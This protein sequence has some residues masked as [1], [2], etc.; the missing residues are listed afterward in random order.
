MT[1]TKI[2]AVLVSAAMLSVMVAC[3]ADEASAPAAPAAA[4][5]AQAAQAITYQPAAPQAAVAAAPAAAAISAPALAVAPAVPKAKPTAVPTPVQKSSELSWMD[6][7]LQGPGYN[8]SWGQPIKGGIMRYGASHKFNG[9]DPNYGH[10]FEGPQFLPTYNALLRYDPWRGLGGQIEGDLA[11]TWEVQDGGKTVV[12]K[13]REGVNFQTNPNLPAEIVDQVS[14]DSFTCEDAKASLDFGVNPPT[15]ILHSGPRAALN[16]MSGSSCIDD[17]TFKVEFEEALARTIPQFAGALG[18]P[19]NMD[20]DFLDWFLNNYATTDPQENVLDQTTPETYMYGTGTGAFVPLEFEVDVQSK[21]RANPDYFREGLPLI[22]G[23]DQFIITDATAR[24]SALIT[25]Q[26]DYYG[27]GSASLLPAHVEQIQ[28][29][30][31]DKFTIQPTLHSW[32]KGI[33]VNLLREPFDNRDVRMAMHLALD[34]DDWV[35]FNMA[36]GISGVHRHTLWMPPGSIWALPDE[37]LGEMP[38]WR[39]GQGKIDDIAEA[40]RLLDAA[41]GAGNRFSVECMAQ[42]A[43]IYIDGCEYFQDQMKRNLGVDVTIS[44]VESAV[45]G[46]RGRGAQYDVHYGSKVRTNVADPDDFYMIHLI[47]ERESWYYRGTGREEAEP[48]LTAQLVELVEKQSRELDVAKRVEIVH[49]IERILATEAMFSIPYPWTYIF[50]A[51]STEIKGW[52]LY[53]HPS[54]NK[55]AQWERMWLDRS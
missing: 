47:K 10:S 40:N 20:K 52:T 54:Q 32:G 44:S 22:E 49:E 31:K 29:R 50:P 18:M 42:G 11:E 35:D 28:A 26:V 53:P 5:P 12:F 41:L 8:P 13:L 25:G 34:R 6:S 51:W 23:M 1:F 39:R 7:Y 15:G 9:H 43:Q 4:A 37:E 27:E 45:Q 19:H 36:A 38:G 30:F 48:E 21:I 3:A 46:D 33:Q 2:L 24:F 55:W 16:H 17:Y 14:G